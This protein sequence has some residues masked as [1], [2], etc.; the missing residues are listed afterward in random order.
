MVFFNWNNSVLGFIVCLFDKQHKIICN[1]HSCWW[2]LFFDW[3]A[4]INYFCFEFDIRGDFFM[5]QLFD[6]FNSEDFY[7]QLY[8][9]KVDNKDINCLLFTFPEKLSDPKELINM[10]DVIPPDN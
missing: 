3:L 9:R 10:P 1:G 5:K 7:V 6:K 8:K 2:S 4:F